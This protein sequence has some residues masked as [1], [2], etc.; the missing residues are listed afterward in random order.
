MEMLRDFC[1]HILKQT[2]TYTTNLLGLKEN[3]YIALTNAVNLENIS[4]E[5]ILYEDIPFK[6]ILIEMISS[7]DVLYF[8]TIHM[9]DDIY[10][11]YTKKAL[12]KDIRF[13]V[14]Y[15]VDIFADRMNDTDL[16]I[17]Y[18]Q[19]SWE[20]RMSDS[21]KASEKIVDTF[22]NEILTR[23]DHQLESLFF[24]E[25][26][27]RFSLIDALSSQAYEKRLC[28]GK[29]CFTN[30]Q[31]TP[32]MLLENHLETNIPFSEDTIRF[33]RKLLQ[34][35]GTNVMVLENSSSEL[36]KYYFKGFCK[37]GSYENLRWWVEITAPLCWKMYYGKNCLFQRIRKELSVPQNEQ[38]FMRKEAF[39]V[40]QKVFRNIKEDDC[41]I[42]LQ[43]A[44]QQ[45]HGTSLLFFDNDC[46]PKLMASFWKSLPVKL[47]FEFMD[48]KEKIRIICNL[49]EMDGAIALKV[50]KDGTIQ[51]TH[52]ALIVDGITKSRGDLSKGSRHNSLKTF[53]ESFSDR[54]NTE[55]FKVC[56][57]VFSEDGG[58]VTYEG[59]SSDKSS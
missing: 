11:I 52:A 57:L 45:K 6:D 26:S 28:T 55:T 14:H 58:M 27:I 8:R 49:M 21:F 59:K 51:M 38:D 34:S 10:Y 47:N 7:E 17:Q 3:N 42:Y 43:A 36:D 39:S 22:S 31:N 18:L 16:E 48:D 29:L 24:L 1:E 12:L 25:Y 20:S 2:F 30:T 44:F 56:A 35:A 37:D 53:V 40:L 50:S 15:Y 13:F 32:R 19:F 33:Y 23:L 46:Y 5:V 4:S 41:D 9:G 54:E